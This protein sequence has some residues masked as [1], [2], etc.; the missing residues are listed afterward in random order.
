MLSRT[1]DHLY[2]IS[3]YMERA[4]NIARFLDVANNLALSAGTPDTVWQPVLTIADGTQTD[5]SV[6]SDLDADGV[7]RWSVLDGQNPSSILSSLRAARENAHAVRSVVPNELWEAIN[8]TWLEARTI[9]WERLMDQGLTAFCDWIKQRSHLYRGVTYGTMI[10]DEAYSFLRLG[11]F[12]ERADDTARLLGVDQTGLTG[13]ETEDE[14]SGQLHWAAVLRSVGA[15]KAYRKAHKGEISANGAAHMLILNAEMPRSL[16]YCMDMI[17]DIL[18]ALA[19]GYECTRLAGAAHA[20]LHFGR[21]DELLRGGLEPFVTS[22]LRANNA[23]G[24]QINAD[25]L[26]AG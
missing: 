2:W 18:T 4:E 14:A 22:Y 6:R 23:L 26:M 10:R 3:R 1:A 21:L 25:F 15:L 12:L 17:T 13:Q 5:E 19:P 9:T 8:S 11:T 20:D 24:I 16:H 7:I